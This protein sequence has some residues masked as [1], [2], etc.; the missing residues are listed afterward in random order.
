MDSRKILDKDLR[1]RER[2]TRIN[3]RLS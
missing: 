3:Q 2:M 1:T